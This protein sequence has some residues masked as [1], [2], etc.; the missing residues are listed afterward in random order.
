MPISTNSDF[1]YPFI[2]PFRIKYFSRHQHHLSAQNVD[3]VSCL[4]LFKDIEE[5]SLTSTLTLRD[6]QD[7]T[8]NPT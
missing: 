5:F 6:L 4:M 1:V 2:K 3:R 7:C 8:F